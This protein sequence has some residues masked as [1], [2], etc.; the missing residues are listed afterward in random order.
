MY[1]DPCLISQIIEAIPWKGH[2]K[3][4]DKVLLQGRALLYRKGENGISPSGHHCAIFN[5]IKISPFLQIIIV[6]P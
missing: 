2:Q 4:K 3:A 1:T 6:L 5:N